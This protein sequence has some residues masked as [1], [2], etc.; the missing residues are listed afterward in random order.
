MP[1]CSTRNQRPPSSPLSRRQH[2]PVVCG[3]GG[4]ALN[5][6]LLSPSLG[7]GFH[8]VV[9]YEGGAMT[10]G[11]TVMTM[12]LVA[13][14]LTVGT[15]DL[16]HGKETDSAT[17]G[18]GG[19]IVAGSVDTSERRFEARMKPVGGHEPTAEG[20]V[21]YRSRGASSEELREEFRVTV[22]FAARNALEIPTPDAAVEASIEVTLSRAGQ[23]Y[24]RCTLELDQFDLVLGVEYTLDLRSRGRFSQIRAGG[25]VGVINGSES[26]TITSTP[27]MPVPKADDT[28]SVSIGEDG[29]V[30]LHG[31]FEPR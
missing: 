18:H 22:E 21:E 23:A 2:L 3:Y 11:R 19:A 16:A 5:L 27:I 24:A 14:G 29:P 7:T 30:F 4:V 28:V 17:K 6:R 8:I 13:F 1:D 31:K 10:D 20:S 9:K 12:V 15:R 25:C 26:E